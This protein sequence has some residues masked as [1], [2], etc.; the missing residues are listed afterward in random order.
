MKV[1]REGQCVEHAQY[2]IGIATES[3]EERTTIEFYEHGRKKFV[4][5]MLQAALVDEAPRR[6]P[7]PR[8]ARPAAKSPKKD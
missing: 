3:N 7:K 5:S 8:N 4:T 6:P 1:L 2:G